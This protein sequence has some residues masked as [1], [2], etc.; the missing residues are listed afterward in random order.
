MAAS[1]YLAQRADRSPNALR[2]SLYT[3]IAYLATVAILVMP[4][5]LVPAELYLLAFGIMIA[6]TVLVIAAFNYYVSVAEREPF[7]SRFGHMA[8]ISLGVAAIS[9]VIGLAARSLLGIEA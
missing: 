6:S 9:F 2:A 4:Y 5:L 7:L 3:G 1:N 8:A